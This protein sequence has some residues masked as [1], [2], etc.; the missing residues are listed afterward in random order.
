MEDHNETGSILSVGSK[1]KY[2]VGQFESYDKY[3][4]IKVGLQHS[5]REPKL[6][7]GSLEM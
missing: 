4:R 1:L 3:S 6:Y 2:L 7:L 5:L